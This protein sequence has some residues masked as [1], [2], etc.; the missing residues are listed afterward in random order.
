VVVQVAECLAVKSTDYLK[1]KMMRPY[2]MK[3]MMPRG[4]GGAGGGMFGR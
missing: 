4:G 3:G 1:I 2:H